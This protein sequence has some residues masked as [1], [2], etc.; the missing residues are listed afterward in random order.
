MS[1]KYQPFP[2]SGVLAR[3]SPSGRLSKFKPNIQNVPNKSHRL[4]PGDLIW[5]PAGTELR[6]A[7]AR[8]GSSQLQEG[9]AVEAFVHVGAKLQ[10]YRPNKH[11]K[12]ECWTLLA[13]VWP[14]RLGIHRITPVEALALVGQEGAQE[15]QE[16][17]S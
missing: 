1:N 15:E 11:G 16:E 17:T 5:L 3:S 4:Q 8:F 2:G 12:K 9:E 14:G 10:V 7:G 6:K 13:A